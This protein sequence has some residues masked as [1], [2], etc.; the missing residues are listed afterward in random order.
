MQILDFGGNKCMSFIPGQ[1]SF[2]DQCITLKEIPA[3]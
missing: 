2:Q 1:L 3:T